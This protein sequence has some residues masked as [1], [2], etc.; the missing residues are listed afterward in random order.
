MFLFCF[1]V[2]WYKKLLKHQNLIFLL[3]QN[4]ELQLSEVQSQ[5]LDVRLDH[6]FCLSLLEEK[7]SNVRLVS[8]S[9]VLF[10]INFNSLGNSIIPYLSIYQELDVLKALGSESSCQDTRKAPVYRTYERRFIASDSAQIISCMKRTFYIRGF[11]FMQDILHC[12]KEQ[13]SEH[14]QEHCYRM[15]KFMGIISEFK[16]TSQLLCR[17]AWNGKWTFCLGWN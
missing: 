8:I 6:P 12:L 15:R 7:L 9:A 2:Q 5:T 17:I 16:T 1:D 11:S 10:P 14:R 4:S 3:I 13:I